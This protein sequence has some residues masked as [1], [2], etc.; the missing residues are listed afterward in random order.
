[1]TSGWDR[2]WI[3][4]PIMSCLVIIQQV[5]RTLCRAASVKCG[6]PVLYPPWQLQNIQSH[7][8]QHHQHHTDHRRPSDIKAQRDGRIIEIYYTT[9]CSVFLCVWSQT[10]LYL[11]EDADTVSDT[12]NWSIGT[13]D[14]T[15]SDDWYEGREYPIRG[16]RRVSIIR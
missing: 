3:K 8:R 10:Q 2:C 6:P 13:A 16:E 1:M 4:L 14:M 15:R 5:Q 9:L 7:T 12:W 11:C